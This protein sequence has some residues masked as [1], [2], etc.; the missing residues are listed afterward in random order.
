[1]SK[2]KLIKKNYSSYNLTEEIP[3]AQLGTILTILN[4]GLNKARETYRDVI[5]SIP[6]F[7]NTNP[8]NKNP[9]QDSNLKKLQKQLYD[10]GAFGK[11]AI[12]K[13]VDG[14]DGPLTQG[15]IQKAKDL[16]YEVNGFNLVKKDQSFLDKLTNAWNNLIGNRKPTL[17]EFKEKKRQ[18]LRDQ[19]ARV[20]SQNPFPNFP[21]MD[22]GPWKGH[23]MDVRG[24]KGWDD[25]RIRKEFTKYAND[26]QKYLKQNPN[27]EPLAKKR[28]QEALDY[29][30]KVAKNPKY[31]DTHGGGFGCIYTA[32]GSYGDDYRNLNNKKLSDDIQKGKDTGFIQIQPD[33][34]VVGD[35]IQLGKN[36]NGIYNPHHAQMVTDTFMGYPKLAQNSAIG[37][38][39]DSKSNNWSNAKNFTRTRR[40][41]G[42]EFRV[43]RFVGTKDQN[44]KWEE[45]YYKL[46]G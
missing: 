10:I 35:I 44:K 19:A 41:L 40:N 46:Y 32:S 16:G 39:Q 26:A 9:K 24:K 6:S 45:E 31:L 33:E 14:K 17:E 18:E 36:T 5:E 12:N 7:N 8:E 22:V 34:Y 2:S 27:L 37:Y 4:K 38:G 29:Y 25:N 1:M 30:K 28:I 23:D 43:L 3:K 11:I 13:A 42:E 21:Q 15:A 20:N